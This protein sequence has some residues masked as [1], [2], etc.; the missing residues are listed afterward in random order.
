MAS[1]SP[2][3]AAAAAAGGGRTAVGPATAAE[4][5]RLSPCDNQMVKQ[6]RGLLLGITLQ[7]SSRCAVH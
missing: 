2:P 6:L 1:L 3:S 5:A 7:Y 4:W